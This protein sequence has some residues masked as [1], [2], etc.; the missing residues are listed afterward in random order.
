MVPLRVASQR[1][2]WRSISDITYPG[3][4]PSVDIREDPRFSPSSFRTS[5]G[6]SH[7][8]AFTSPTFRP[9][10][11]YPICRASRTWQSM[12]RS[13]ARCAVDRPVN[14]PPT[15]GR[16]IAVHFRCEV[17]LFGGCIP[18]GNRMCVVHCTGPAVDLSAWPRRMPTM[19]YDYPAVYCPA[20]YCPASRPTATGPDSIKAPLRSRPSAD[21]RWRPIYSPT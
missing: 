20:V 15:I 7:R 17:R 11:P 19:K 9:E 1:I 10:P 14:P 8:P 4:S 18:E 12:P 6:G 5:C 13:A 21:D 16:D 2:W 3:A